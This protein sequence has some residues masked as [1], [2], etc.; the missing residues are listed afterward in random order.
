M[1]VIAAVVVVVVSSGCGRRMGN[2]RC[3]VRRED[4]G[5]KAEVKASDDGIDSRHSR[6]RGEA[7]A[8]M[9]SVNESVYSCIWSDGCCYVTCPI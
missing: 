1:V 3:S 5:G 4:N 9:A 6:D 8:A 2:S 7:V